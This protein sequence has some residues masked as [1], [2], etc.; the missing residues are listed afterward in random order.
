MP[1]DPGALAPGDVLLYGGTGLFNRIIQ[2]KTW[3]RYSHVEVYD[4]GGW[5]LASR[6]GIGVGRY[7]AR[8]DDAL[9]VYRLRVPFDLEAGRAYFAESEGQGYD[10]WGLL[11]FTSAK[12]QGRDNGKQFCSEFAARWCR[13]AIGAKAHHP[14]AKAGHATALAVLG[15]DPWNGYDADGISPGE[16][17]KSALL[18]LEMTS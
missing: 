8:I 12:F 7:P 10:W 6:N 9:A 15:L 17:A 2:V 1:I 5:S 13:R 11:A 16:F 14:S 18:R 4:G 3:S